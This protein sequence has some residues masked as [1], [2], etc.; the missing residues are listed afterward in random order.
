MEK[1]GMKQP[2]KQILVAPD[3][4]REVKKMGFLRRYRDSIIASLAMFLCIVYPNIAMRFNPP[5]AEGATEILHGMIL[6]AQKQHSNI[7]LQMP[8]GS[9]QALDFPADL[10]GIYMAKFQYFMLPNAEQF[11]RLKGCTADIQID[12]LH[13]LLIPTNPRIW[14][15]RC[16]RFSISYNQ[17]VNYYHTRGNL[18]KFRWAIFIVCFGMLA[19]LIFGDFIQG[20][21]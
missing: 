2:G 20:R 10:Q 15:L 21:K 8:D 18:G 19:L 12:H 5:P 11:A 17:I 13:G 3:G 14:S 16:D 1:S 7:I 9:E 6:R 4:M